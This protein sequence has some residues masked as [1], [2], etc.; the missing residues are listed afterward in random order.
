ML[1]VQ[2]NGVG[3]TPERLQELHQRLAR[4]SSISEEEENAG[5]S[6]FALSNVQERLA[7]F[8]AGASLQVESVEGAGTRIIIHITVEGP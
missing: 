5:R 4:G 7:L 1:E 2:D 6:G 3:I 8:F